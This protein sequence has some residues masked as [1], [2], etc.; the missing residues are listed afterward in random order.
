MLGKPKFPLRHPPGASPGGVRVRRAAWGGGKHLIS[1]SRRVP[2]PAV[3]NT[4]PPSSTPGD[5]SG[6]ARNAGKRRTDAFMNGL[7]VSLSPGSPIF[8]FNYF[9]FPLPFSPHTCPAAQSSLADMAVSRNYEIV[10]VALLICTPRAD[11]SSSWS[12]FTTKFPLSEKVED[13]ELLFFL[14]D[15]TLGT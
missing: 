10:D 7:F 1:S 9:F 15:V 2:A 8:F 14:R 11:V 12:F 13:K 3:G 6:R 5:S 4:E